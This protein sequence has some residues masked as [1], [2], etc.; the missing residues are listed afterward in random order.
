MKSG[1]MK[2]TEARIRILIPSLVLAAL[3]LAA[4]AM[5]AIAYGVIF[6]DFLPLLSLQDLSST[7]SLLGINFL[8]RKNMLNEG[9]MVLLSVDTRISF[10]AQFKANQ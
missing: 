6:T 2:P 8:N 5:C 4:S 10:D 3:S 1:A 9:S 7:S